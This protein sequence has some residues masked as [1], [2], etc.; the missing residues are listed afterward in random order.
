M[1]TQKLIILCLILALLASLLCL[2]A[3]SAEVSG[4]DALSAALEQGGEVKLS[5]D[6]TAPAERERILEIPK[7]VLAS[8]D[9]N[10][11]TLDGG[12]P[13]EEDCVILVR[14]TEGFS[15]P[16]T[17]FA[18]RRIPPQKAIA[19]PV[20]FVRAKR[21]SAKGDAQTYEV[22]V[23]E[24]APWFLMARGKVLSP[25][26][27]GKLTFEFGDLKGDDL[28]VPLK[29]SGGMMTLRGAEFNRLRP[30][31]LKKGRNTFTFRNL[32]DVTV[33][34]VILTREP[35]TLVRNRDYPVLIGK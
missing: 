3:A 22:T 14:G 29:W 30:V 10:G 1:K 24:E 6:V 26:T 21:I 12:T 31:Y 20:R 18:D 19:D 2:P 15:Y 7:G 11:F 9:L 16:V 8:L 25:K 33:D 5:A 17:L 28:L 32:K 13:G 27:K 35:E 34:E 23:S 4:W